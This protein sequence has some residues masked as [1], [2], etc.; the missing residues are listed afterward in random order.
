[1]RFY[2][3]LS[4]FFCFSNANSAKNTIFDHAL[5]KLSNYD[6]FEKSLNKH[7]PKNNVISYDIASPLFSDYADKIRFIRIHVMSKILFDDENN[8]IYPED[9]HL[10]KTFFHFSDIRE[11]QSKKHI[12][13]TRVLKNTS[14][15]WLS[16]LYIWNRIQII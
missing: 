1:M 5:S 7:I 10:I 9:S 14:L 6:F 3:L 13:E 4:I 15:G 11:H 12:F 8:F 2:Y 16:F